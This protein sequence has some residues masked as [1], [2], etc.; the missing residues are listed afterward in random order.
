LSIEEIRDHHRLG[1]REINQ[2]QA[3]ELQDPR[4]RTNKLPPGSR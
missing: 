2:P 3:G 1:A 4:L